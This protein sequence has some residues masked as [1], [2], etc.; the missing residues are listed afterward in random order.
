MLL[1]DFKGNY[2]TIKSIKNI[3]NYNQKGLYTIV[4][5]NGTGKSAIG[6]CLCREPNTDVLIIDETNYSESVITSFINHNTLINMFHPSVKIVFIDDIN[7]ISHEKT[8]Q[9]LLNMNHEKCIIFCT[10]RTN[11]EKKIVTL[12]LS[13]TKRFELQ[14]LN[15]KDCYHLILTTMTHKEENIN[16]EKLIK[17][18]KSLKCNIP[19][20][21]M[22]LDSCTETNNF[23]IPYEEIPEKFDKNTYISTKY[24][25][26]KELDNHELENYVRTESPILSTMIHHNILQL[27]FLKSNED[28]QTIKQV[29][30]VFCESDTLDKYIYI[31]C[32]W[33]LLHELNVY[34]KYS[35]IN[36][37]LK[38]H[39]KD[40]R[41]LEFSKH[42][43]KLSSQAA[44]RKKL[45]TVDELI[46]IE[47]PLFY[48]K[49]ISNY[50][51]KNKTKQTQIESLLKK[52]HDDFKNI[53][54][55]E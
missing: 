21:M 41:N 36:K 3:V 26:S 42:F 28:I 7:L 53:K 50:A 18:V 54:Q 19:K 43:T 46:F 44:F 30:K 13:I 32:D 52:Y 6:I 24:F 20:I 8:L 15:Y 2:N 33:N 49:Y 1:S 34:Y 45:Y 11:N 27:D 38:L 22:M 17:L 25:F 29:Y 16:L 51:S 14:V 37:L 40:I 4:G 12:K 35:F 9:K 10:V 5:D 31:N 39:Y 55:K 47:H 48:L 23:L